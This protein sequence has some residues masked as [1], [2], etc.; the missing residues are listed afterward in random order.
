QETPAPLIT[1]D[2][3]KV[4]DSRGHSVRAIEEPNKRIRS[5]T[6]EKTRFLVCSAGTIEER[7]H[8]LVGVVEAP[9]EGCLRSGH[10]KCRKEIVRLRISRNPEQQHHSYQAAEETFHV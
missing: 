5:A 6:Q 4:N 10:V 2:L 7:P 8:D 1:H 9:S 3:A